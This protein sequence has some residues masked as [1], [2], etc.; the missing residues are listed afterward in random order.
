[1]VARVEDDFISI[2]AIELISNLE[3]HAFF[4]EQTWRS[5]KNSH[6]NY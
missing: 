3:N 4:L 1:M 2:E 6:M 5:N